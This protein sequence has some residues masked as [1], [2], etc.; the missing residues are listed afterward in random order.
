MNGLK[1]K[2]AVSLCAGLMLVTVH[3]V[4]A[5]DQPKVKGGDSHPVMKILAEELDYAMKNLVMPDGTKPYYLGYT[6]TGQ[7]SFSVSATLGALVSENSSE[8]RVLD[9]DVRVGDYAIDNTHKLRGGGGGR[10]GSG[11]AAI[12]LSDDEAAIR[13]AIWLT[14]DQQFK[15]AAQMYQRVQT[16]LKTK[17]EEEDK[18]DDFSREE[19][20]VYSEKEASLFLDKAEWTKRIRNLSKLALKYPL[21]YSSGVSLSAVTAN[22]YMVTSEGTRV[23]TGQKFIRIS[24]SANTKAEDGM[25]LGRDFYFNVCHEENLPTDAELIAAFQEVIDQVIALRDAPLVE[26]YVGPAI[27]LNRAA[28]VFFHEIFGHR[29]EGHRQKDVD[30]GQTFTKK[31]NEEVLPTF[32]SV[33]DDPTREK[34]NGVDLRGYYKFDDEGVKAQDVLLIDNGILKTFLL[35]R[36]PVEGFPKSNGHGRRTP[37][38]AVVSRQGNLIV[39]SAK[40]VSFEELRQQ[41]IAECKKQDKPYGLLFEDITGGFTTTG[42][43]GPQAFKVLPVIVRRIY[44]DG[45]PDELVRGVDIVGTPLSCFAK[46]TMTGDDSE[47]FNGTCGAE[48][49]YVPVSAVSPSVLVS[50]IEIEKR[51][52]E[53][54]KP[55]ILPPPISE[56]VKKADSR[57]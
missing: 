38:R 4:S 24:V 9:V 16:N 42:R 6:I 55:P 32:L 15:A 3:T 29:I 36:S 46:I 50:Q 10:M 34:F 20:S 23:Q 30:E 54:D 26:P 27:L 45:R 33:R 1:S 37:G 14:T 28:G 49:G 12:S 53:Q 18:S 40:Q 51:R 35:S 22:R 5:G 31:I 19:P 17:V 21:I 52:R 57:G 11:V 25:E 39:E 48:S 13:Q 41:L 44:A 43:R 56:I 47:V 7:E 2:F 8:G